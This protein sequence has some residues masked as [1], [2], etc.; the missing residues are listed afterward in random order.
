[1]PLIKQNTANNQT[2]PA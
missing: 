2:K 1:M